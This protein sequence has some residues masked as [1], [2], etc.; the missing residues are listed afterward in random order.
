MTAHAPVDGFSLVWD[1]FAAFFFHRDDTDAEFL[2]ELDHQHGTRRSWTV[3]GWQVRVRVT[4]A[5]LEKEGIAPGAAVATLAGN[6][7]DA[8]ALA[9]AC[10]VLG[11]CVVP[12]N[13]ADSPERQRFIIRDAD[14]RLLVHGDGAADRAAE[15][16]SDG[17]RILPTSALPVGGEATDGQSETADS[18][19]NLESV[20][21]RVYTSGTTGDPKGVVLTVENLL[22]DCDALAA[23]LDWPADTRI[24]TVLRCTMSTVW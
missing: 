8:L 11:A 3:G 4:V 24:L 19:T 1:S 15:L 12:L 2:V 5:W 13:P 17:L 10:W 9:Y 16:V 18:P 23:G 21:L 14:A 7:A 22:T 6:T 20:A